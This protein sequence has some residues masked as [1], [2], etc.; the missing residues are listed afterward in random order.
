MENPNFDLARYFSA[1]DKVARWKAECENSSAR[2][3]LAHHDER[4]AM[5]LSQHEPV[6]SIGIDREK[7]R[8][9]LHFI[10]HGDLNRL[11]RDRRDFTGI[12]QKQ[13]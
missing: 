10:Q 2:L 13:G 12:P 6:F 1:T 7:L 8:L 4:M 9:I 3:E 5:L 11:E